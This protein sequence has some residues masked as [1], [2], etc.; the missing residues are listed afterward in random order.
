MHTVLTLRP[1][2]GDP[3]TL[4]NQTALYNKLD[5]SGNPEIFYRPNNNQTPIQLTYPS[6]NTTQGAA[7]QYSFVAGPFVIYGGIIK[8][9]T[10]G[11]TITLT[12]VTTLLYV[13]LTSA[14][15]VPKGLLSLSSVATNISGNSF[16]ISYSAPSI[17][18]TDVYYL[19]I[20]I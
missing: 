9:A 14:N 16:V 2:I 7:Q 18:S 15:V 3:T 5:G 17:T 13:G 11:Q 1:Q 20:G 4:A 8:N 12:P 6:L 19:A 10:N